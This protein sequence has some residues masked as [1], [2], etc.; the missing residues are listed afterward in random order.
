MLE[1]L[2]DLW[3]EKGS[4]RFRSGLIFVITRFLNA[5]FVVLLY[6]F[7]VKI[8]L[9]ES[10]YNREAIFIFILVFSVLV[11][12]PIQEVIE[13]YL[14]R[15]FLSEYLFDDSSSVRFAYRNFE[16]K[17]LIST[18]FPDM[19]KIAG[20]A[21]GRMIIQKEPEAF[22]AYS[23]TEG[24]SR[25]IKT[26]TFHLNKD[27][28]KYLASK[29]DIVTIGEEVDSNSILNK[30]LVELKADCIIP[31]VYRD[32]TFGF[33]S[34]SKIPDSTALQ[35]LRILASK[36]AIAVYNHYLAF[37]VSRLYKYRK[38]LE[39]A[40]RIQEEVFHTTIP[41]FKTLSVEIL[42]RDPNIIL[43]FFNN[44]QSQEIVMVLL[45]LTIPKF[46][47]GLILSHV[48]GKMF[49]LQ[50]LKK[51]YT[52]KVLRQFIDK[53]FEEINMKDGYE[54]LIGVYDEKIRRITFTQ[55]GT[56]FKVMNE[57]Q[58]GGV[59]LGWKYTLHFNQLKVYHKKSEILIIKSINHT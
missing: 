29:K 22:E 10:I 11:L 4:F 55:V 48:L 50:I 7:L 5:T 58:E 45:S 24:K 13:I 30:S 35:E 28:L 32:K 31:F 46:G 36:A 54:L 43:E 41:N 14:K 26:Q 37:Q 51:T 27:L 49:Y 25:R 17:T 42:K 40:D 9:F 2:K 52:H 56:H 38:E 44:I 34:L 47:S 3:I 18:V 57:K 1:I 20:A 8:N 16:L 33:L 59:S 21:S 12:I 15:K 53:V 19:V 39:N 23:Y 6:F